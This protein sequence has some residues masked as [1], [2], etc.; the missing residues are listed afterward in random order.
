MIKDI[1][2]SVKLEFFEKIRVES[3]IFKRILDLGLKYLRPILSQFLCSNT[4]LSLSFLIHKAQP[5]VGKCLEFVDRR[6]MVK[7]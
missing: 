7:H 6:K 1:G 2:T 4:N 3:K 5:L